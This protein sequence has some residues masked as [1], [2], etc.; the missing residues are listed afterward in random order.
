MR[1]FLEL[2]AYLGGEFLHPGARATT[3]ALLPMLGLRLGGRALELGCGTGAT[4]VLVA[5]TLGVRVTMLDRS[6]A[7][8]VA[9]HD[10]LRKERLLREV[11]LLRAD[12]GRSWPFRDATFD[13]VYA[14]SAVALLEI[15]SVI[16]ECARVLRSRG[17]LALT[18]RI[19][20]PG[21]SQ[22]LADEV[23]AISRR[24]FGIP[25]ATR[26]PLDRSAWLH[27]LHQSGLVNEHAIPVDTLL[28]AVHSGQRL[29]A[30]VC[31]AG[32]YLARPQII[33]QSV[34]FKAMARKHQRL[35]SHLECYVFLAQKP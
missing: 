30:R 20:R 32:R 1:G 15:E 4:A 2:E 33:W 35:W 13:A 24:A 31:R 12:A 23:N 22:A 16:G 27:L 14:E 11:N 10:R 21:V 8:L 17:H 6:L 18:E 3:E 19:W 5:R 9:A 7:M 34:W 26:R 29:W 28:A 25:A